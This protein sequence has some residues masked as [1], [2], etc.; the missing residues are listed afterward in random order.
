M[1]RLRQK[2]WFW[3]LVQACI[4]AI[5][6]AWRFYIGVS[7]YLAHPTDGDLYAHTWSF[8]AIVFLVFRLPIILLAFGAWLGLERLAARLLSHRRLTNETAST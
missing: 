8:Q 5:I 6:V 4:V 3:A 7:N 1:T 2:F